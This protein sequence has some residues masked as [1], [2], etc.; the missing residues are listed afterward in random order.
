MNPPHLASARRDGAAGRQTLGL[1]AEEEW[2]VTQLTHPM[3]FSRGAVGESVS[4]EMSTN[5]LSPL[6][7]FCSLRANAEASTM[8]QLTYV[9]GSRI[10]W[11]DVP[12]PKLMDAR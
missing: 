2:W 12:E 9:G 10:E 6:T 4:P 8:R 5:L 3:E 7:R 1:S 11:W